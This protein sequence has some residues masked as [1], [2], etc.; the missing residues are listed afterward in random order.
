M[1]VLGFRSDGQL[2]GCKEG[3]QAAGI[4]AVFAEGVVENV[5]Q[6]LDVTRNPV[7]EL[8][9]LRLVPDAL[10]GIK[11]GCIS[12]Q[13]FRSKPGAAGGQEF[14]DG[15]S[16]SGE[17]IQN[18]EQRPPQVVVHAAKKLNDIVGVRVMVEQ[19]VVQ[20]EPTRPWR[21]AERGQGGDAVVPI[22]SVLHWRMAALG[23]DP[24]PQRL[25]Q[26]AAFID[27]N[28]AS[29]ALS[30][31]FLIAASA[32]VSS[33]RFLFRAA[34]GRVALVSADSSRGGGGAFRHN[35]GDSR[36]QTAAESDSARAARTSHRACSPR[37]ANPV[38]MPKPAAAVAEASASA[39]V[40]DAAWPATPARLHDARL[41][42]N[43]WQRR[44]SN[45]RPQPL[46]PAISP[47]QKAGLPHVGEL[48]AL[49]G[50]LGVSCTI[51]RDSPLLFHSQ[52]RTQ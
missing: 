2:G 41:P 26:K 30:A 9:V 25:Q 24:S 40:P 12:G 48:P 27:E 15:S 52:L 5:V 33:G 38:S 35:R 36:R 23:P 37:K 11:F 32:R 16:M 4:V 45:Q 39:D 8:A 13:P 1:A 19:F 29:L 50:F 34:R 7:G 18:D 47:A 46:A 43:D 3:V 6:V 14:S 49:R 22:P 21:P 20:A 44:Y 17:A 10:D 51:I 31:L 28:Q 42:S